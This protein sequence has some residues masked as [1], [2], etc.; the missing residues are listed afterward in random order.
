MDVPSE[1]EQPVLSGS[2]PPAL[3]VSGS[4]APGSAPLAPKSEPPVAPGSAPGSAS[5]P[6]QDAKNGLYRADANTTIVCFG[7]L[8]GTSLERL[9]HPEGAE[10]ESQTNVL[11]ST[12]SNLTELYDYLTV[13][14]DG[15]LMLKPNVILVYLGDVFGDGPNNIELATTLLKLKKDNLTRV[16]IISGNRDLILERLPYELQ[17]ADACMVELTNRV[18][19][20]VQ[21][22]GGDAFDGFKFEF[23]RNNPAHFDYMWKDNALVS[24]QGLPSAEH[25]D[26]IASNRTCLG[27]VTYVKEV[28]M[29]EYYGWVF[30]VDEYLT[31]KGF[32]LNKI[33]GISHETKSY[34]YVYLV[35]VMAMSGDGAIDCGVPE[36]NGIFEKLLMNGHLIACI[37]AGDQGKFGFM[38][39]L[40]PRGKIPTIP[41]SIYKEQYDAAIEEIGFT[42]EE[43]KENGTV[44]N[45][46]DFDITS[47]TKVEIN[48][49]LREFNQSF[50]DLIRSHRSN[51][52]IW[53][54]LLECVSGTTSGSYWAYLNNR[55]TGANMPFATVSFGLAGFKQYDIASEKKNQDGGAIVELQD[56]IATQFIDVNDFTHVVCSHSPKGYVGVKVE[57]AHG[58]TYYCIDVSKIDDQEYDVKERFGCCFLILDLSKLE[59]GVN[60]KFIGRIM[61]KQSQFPKDYDIFTG[62][63]IKDTQ[64]IKP[65]YANYVISPIPSSTKKELEQKLPLKIGNINYDFE[66]K[67]GGK[68]NRN[69]KRNSGTKLLEYFTKMPTLTSSQH[70]MSAYGGGSR[71]RK[72]PS[73]YLKKSARTTHKRRISKKLAQKNN[74]RKNKK[75]KRSSTSRQ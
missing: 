72:R 40:P 26:N 21:G 23:E 67:K 42:P 66:Y 14:P 62:T 12:V 10:P 70:F 33:L 73:K 25:K 1:S 45:V 56:S 74:K 16:I 37:D 11:T 32:T 7:D 36:F 39:S 55:K 30:L 13:S 17:P 24:K 29:T 31:K 5:T 53:R 38:H 65:M 64:G 60:D 18:K 57:T 28:S 71:T 4:L 34:I 3:P 15:T 44:G 20:F 27:R 48:E 8:E 75:S 50:R 9:I 69:I 6:E 41:G 68:E 59:G 35:Q 61:L 19:A 49:G 47:A 46:K 63:T 58:K 54:E 43:Q 2:E 52:R 22:G 51:H